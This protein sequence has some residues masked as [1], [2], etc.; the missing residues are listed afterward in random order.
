MVDQYLNLADIEISGSR[1]RF[2]QSAGWDGGVLARSLAEIGLLT[3]LLVHCYGGRIHLA[4]GF[5]R[6]A[7]ARELGWS[8]ISCRLL[9][10]ETALETLLDIVLHE[11]L[12]PV[13]ASTAG[14][15][16]FIRWSLGLGL[17][18]KRLQEKFFP[19]LGIEPHQRLLRQYLAVAKLPEQVL[20][21]CEAK[22]FSLKQ[23]VHLTRHPQALLEQIF[24]WNLSMS[25]S[26]LTELL[27]SFRHYMRVQELSQDELIQD[28]GFREILDARISS[29]ERTNR[30]RAWI[31]T[32]CYPMLSEIRLRMEETR[33]HIALPDNVAL[34]WDESLERRELRFNI[35]IREPE[36]L[37]AVFSEL[38]KPHIL[39][40]ISRLFED[41]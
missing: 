33:R 40:Y 8:E 27:E 1:Y 12:S 37:D 4:D 20:N 35:R 14:R 16:R 25:A 38:Q 29:Q 3:P 5:Q 39:P 34:Q 32:R 18:E 13:L 19:P 2:I 21:F 23:C 41:L 30:V 10:D 36:E 17:P 26:I 15:V 6:A 22:R 31:R 24:H 28:P 11:Q 7:C 9:P